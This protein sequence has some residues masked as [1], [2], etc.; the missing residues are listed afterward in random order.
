MRP[1]KTE[2]GKLQEKEVDKIE[3]LFSDDD[4]N[5]KSKNRSI[6]LTNVF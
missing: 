5:K 6:F 3:W 4:H 2:K 1:K